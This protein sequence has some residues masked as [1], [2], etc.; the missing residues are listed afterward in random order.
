MSI[1]SHHDEFENYYP[2]ERPQGD[3]ISREALR[4]AF[5]KKIYYFDKSSWDEANALIDNAPTIDLWQIRQEATENALKKAKMLYERPQ[6]A[7]CE[8]CPFKKFSEDVADKIAKIMIDNGITDFDEFAKRLGV[9][10]L[11]QDSITKSDTKI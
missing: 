9:S 4:E 6:V 11:H 8:N 5:H 7:D 2:Y 1:L 10:Y 3:L